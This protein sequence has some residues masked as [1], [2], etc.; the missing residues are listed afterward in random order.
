MQMALICSEASRQQN[1]YTTQSTEKEN[2]NHPP[3]VFSLNFWMLSGAN[4]L[5]SFQMIWHLLWKPRTITLWCPVTVRRQGPSPLGDLTNTTVMVG[6]EPAGEGHGGEGW[7]GMVPDQTG[8]AHSMRSALQRP[9]HK[10]HTLQL[11][12]NHTQQTAF[13]LAC[14]YWV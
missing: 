3:K 14:F 9:I 10:H 5:L 1:H 12:Q 8:K 7:K 4:I 13:I 11:Y 6:R 2:K